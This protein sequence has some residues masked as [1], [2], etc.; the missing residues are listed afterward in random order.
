MEHHTATLQ[1]VKMHYVT[2]G[3]AEETIVLLHGWPQTWYAWRHVI[4]LLVDA[5]YRVVAPDLR[6]IG[7][8]SR[9]AGGCNSVAVAGDIAE[10]MADHLDIRR[11]HLV[12]HDWGGPAAFALATISPAAVR[13]LAIVDVTLPGLG[14]DLSQGGRRWHHGFH[15][16]PEL[17][18]ALTEGREHI[19]LGWF[20]RTFSRQTDAVGA[21]DMAEYLRYYTQPG[22]LSSSFAYYRSIPECIA[23]NRAL[24]DKGYRLPMPALGVG[25]GCTEARGR[26]DEP[27]ISLRTVADDVTEVVIAGSG[28]LVP[29]EKPEELVAAMLSFFARKSGPHKPET[30]ALHQARPDPSPTR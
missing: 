10:L 28:H 24:V 14:P 4:P 13:T 5:G 12:G 20:Y 30:G 27:A 17:P 23:A 18:E 16:T 15:M 9:P 19:Y 8:T 29:E 21:A 2:S 25:G 22:A 11:F 7:G 1:H 3:T 6:G 26:V